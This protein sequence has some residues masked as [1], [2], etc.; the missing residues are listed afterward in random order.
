MLVQGSSLVPENGAEE[1]HRLRQS[2]SMLRF[3]NDVQMGYVHGGVHGGE[4]S[5]WWGSFTVEFMVVEYLHS[6]VHGDG[7]SSWGFMVELVGFLHGGV[8][9]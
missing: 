8:P 9:S 3:N 2:L 7:V 1:Y 6:G 5:S 4:V